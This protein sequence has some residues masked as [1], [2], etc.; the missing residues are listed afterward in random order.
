MTCVTLRFRNVTPAVGDEQGGDPTKFKAI[1][2][3]VDR[4]AHGVPELESVVVWRNKVAAH[5]AITHPF[6]HDDIATL[7]MSVMFPVTL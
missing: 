7:G 5:F 2:E 4:Y 1:K 6:K 3:S